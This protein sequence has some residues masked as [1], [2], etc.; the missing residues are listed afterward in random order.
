MQYFSYLESKIK[1][2]L[3]YQLPVSFNKFTHKELLAHSLGALLYTPGTRQDISDI[4]INK[5]YEG[6]LSIAICL[7]DSIGESDVESAEKNVIDQLKKLSQYYN[8]TLSDLPLIF[9]R[10]RNY[11]QFDKMLNKLNK[12]E[13]SVLTGFIFPKCS[14]DS[15][16]NYFNLIKKINLKFSIHLYAMPILETKEIIFVENRIKTLLEIKEVCDRHSQIILNVRIGAT[17]FSGVYGLRRKPYHSIYDISVINACLSDIINIFGRVE[18]QYTL[19]APVWEYFSNEKNGKSTFGEVPLNINDS[20]LI[21]ELLLDR[22][23]GLSGKTI[24]HPSHI[25]PVNFMQIVEKEDYL[26]AIMILDSLKSGGV[27]KSTYENKMNEINPHKE[28]AKKII[29][30]SNLFGVF[31][32]GYSYKSIF[33]IDIEKATQL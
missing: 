28:W 12:L 30:K 23:N 13:L 14:K 19:S 5:K 8:G 16:E 31:E 24:I 33:E 10:P 4:I 18:A 21:K 29:A 1:D 15:L 11:D 3:F 7:E 2:D 22:Q 32:D 17:D 20:G 6:L 25:S 9:V 27:K 26:D